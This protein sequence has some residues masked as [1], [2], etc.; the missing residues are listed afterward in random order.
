MVTHAHELVPSSEVR[1]HFAVLDP[2]QASG[3]ILDLRIRFPLVA[4][5]KRHARPPTRHCSA[6]NIGPDGPYGQRISCANS[7]NICRTAHV[8]GPGVRRIRRTSV[9]GSGL[10][11]GAPTKSRRRRGGTSRSPTPT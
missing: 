3:A 2:V 9:I 6:G 7:A 1:E 5:I 10:G 4:D 11:G 8:N